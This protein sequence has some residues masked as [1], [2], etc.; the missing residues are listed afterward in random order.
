MPV[1]SF[2]LSLV[3]SIAAVLPDAPTLPAH[4][5]PRWRGPSENGH[6]AETGLPTK[7][8]DADVAWKTSLPGSGQSSP[9][10]WGDRIFL[11]AALEQGR[12]RVVFCVDRKTGKV[13]WQ[14]S[15]WKGEPE[16]VHIMNGWASATCA[17]DGEI[18]VAFFGIGGI[19]AYSVDGV[20]LWSR[21]LGKFVSPWGVSAC[22]IIVDDK[23][24][25]NCDADEDGY[26]A[27]LDK[28]TGDII[29]RTERR[30]KADDEQS[31]R[32]W[33]TPIVVSAAGRREIVVNGHDGVRAYD[34]NSGKE[35]WYCK[36]FNGRGEPT[37]TPAGDVLTVVNGLSGD[38]YAV[39]PGGEGDVTKTHMAWHVPRKD[40][41]DCPSPIVV[42]KY[43]IVVSMSGIATCYDA[44]DGRTYWKE[45]LV[46]KFSAS[47]IAADGLAYL[48]NEDGTTYIVR[49]G[50]SLNV[51]AENPLTA[52]EQEIFRASITPCDGQLLVRS[53]NVLY[54]VGKK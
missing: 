4:A 2:L 37:V 49:P 53:T 25:Q 36:S 28:R 12:E 26:I 33:S 14:Q 47:P 31:M 40:G 8:T 17:T 20:K 16:K 9:I 11:T 29:W 1:A 23:V 21:D 51:V 50:E 44:A 52:G 7:W 42:G 43:V 18:V 45:R 54:C 30:L 35:L 15:A 39:K 10:V 22:P 5:W 27:A 34:P 19:H 6:S 38:F 13:L 24:I 32:G 3:L 46:G 48:L 41:R